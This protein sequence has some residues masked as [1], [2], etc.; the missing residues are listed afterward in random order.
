MTGPVQVLVVGFEEASYS[1][2]VLAELRRLREA[3]VVRLVDVLLVRRGE[4][5]DFE[6]LPLPPGADPDLGRIAAEILGGGGDEDDRD[7]ETW[8]LADAVEP[9]G[10][11]AVALL[12]HLWAASL[13]DAIDTAGGR[14][15]GELWLSP[16]DRDLIPEG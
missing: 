8:S 4:D 2:V 15:L 3:G 7:P 13:L 16:A 6:T 9:G 12:E 1:G 14:P 11:A 10:V 5:G